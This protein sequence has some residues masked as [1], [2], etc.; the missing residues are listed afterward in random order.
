MTAASLVTSLVLRSPVATH[1][2]TIASKVQTVPQPVT[3]KSA[4]RMAVAA[5]AA[6]APTLRHVS[7][8][9]VWR[10]W[11]NAMVSP[12]KGAAMELC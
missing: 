8:G 10:Q 11:I 5:P 9:S 4:D 12:L 6:C 3:E 2:V 7:P 1:R